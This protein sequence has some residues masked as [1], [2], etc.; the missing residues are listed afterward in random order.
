MFT[1]SIFFFWKLFVLFGIAGRK[2]SWRL[3]KSPAKKPLAMII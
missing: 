3:V 2:M 1:F